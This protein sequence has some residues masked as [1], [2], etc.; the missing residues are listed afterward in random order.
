[1]AVEGPWT[2][3]FRRFVLWVAVEGP[4][5]PT[6][7]RFV[8]WVAVEGPWTP[9]FRRFDFPA[10]PSVKLVS[11]TSGSS[12]ELHL[13][14]QNCLMLCFCL[15][16]CLFVFKQIGSSVTLDRFNVLLVFDFSISST[17][18]LTL[19]LPDT[20]SS[21]IVIYFN[22]IWNSYQFK[23]ILYSYVVCCSI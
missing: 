7:R 6:F 2:P 3:T 20:S 18:Q 1:M 14:I 5:T 22:V 21:Y 19:Y 13:I 12:H 17:F 16:V 11:D 9:T 4:W 15:F 10:F 23:I 8:L